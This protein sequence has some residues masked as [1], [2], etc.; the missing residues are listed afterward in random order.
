MDNFIALGVEV[1]QTELDVRV[2]EVPATAGNQTQQVID[3]YNTVSACVKTEKCVGTT[4]W[5]FDD[6]YSWV[7]STFAGQGWADLFFQPEGPNTT[8]VK[9]AAYD[10]VIEALMGEP[11]STP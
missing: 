2:T 11:V 7:P 1:A 8:L 3:Y 4:V 6:T 9:K 5:D 10:G